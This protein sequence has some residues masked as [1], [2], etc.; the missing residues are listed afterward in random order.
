MISMDRDTHYHPPPY[1]RENTGA[2][3][4][5]LLFCSLLALP[6][7]GAVAQTGPYLPADLAY[8]MNVCTDTSFLSTDPLAGDIDDL[9][10]SNRGC[11]VVNERN[12]TW[13]HIRMA[14]AGTVGLTL[15]GTT[16][17]DLDF[18]VWGPFS[19]PPAVLDG[20]PLRCSWAAVAG[21]TGMSNVAVDHSEN[22]GGDGWVSDMDVLADE[23]YLIYVTNFS[24]NGAEVALSWQLSNGASFA[25]LQA[26]ITGFTA[27]TAMIE[28]G[29]TVS[30]TDITEQDPFAWEWSFQ[31]AT[32][33]T[34]SDQHPADVLYPEPG[35]F[36]VSLTA[37][38]AAGEQTLNTT[39][40]VLVELITGVNGMIQDRFSFRPVP[41][42]LIVNA[43][44]G[45]SFT[46]VVYDLVGKE[47]QAVQAQGT[48]VLSRLPVGPVFV[49]IQQSSGTFVQK[50]VIQ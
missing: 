34:S 5:A 11:L 36:D 10:G 6:V 44:D 26:P 35:C 40:Q 13:I 38:N 19:T 23:V 9:N 42:G 37:F 29:Q 2:M 7:G 1:F 47:L 30:F 25:C 17:T 18:A 4:T 50:V 41:T 45:S 22:A 21:A 24:V 20:P 12:G 15:Q 31:G 48:A 46:A 8:A 33:A 43:W 39:C 3:R 16:T 32:P 49:R 28:P 27:S 14:S